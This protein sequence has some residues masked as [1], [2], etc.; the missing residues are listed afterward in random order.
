VEVAVP[1]ASISLRDVGRTFG[2]TRAL[3]D[4]DLDLNPGVIGLLGP[5]GAGK[6]TTLSILATVLAPD[7]GSLRI[8]GFD[9]Y[10]QK[11]GIRRS[12]GFVPQ[13]IALYPSLTAAE[14]L[15]L[16]LRMHGLNRGAARDACA[17]TLQVVGLADRA[18]DPV[19]T[20]SGGMQRRLNLA[21]GI[22]H[23]P[24]ILLL[25]EPTTGVDPQSRN[26]ILRTI[27]RLADAGA[28][29]LYSTHYMEEVER[30]CDRVLLIDRGRVIA[31]GSVAE[32][33]A[34]ADKRPRI[35]FTFAARTTNAWYEGI[36]AIEL[37]SPV[38]AAGRLTL[39][40]ASVDAVPEL[41]KRA[42]ELDGGL[43]DFT[44]RSANL[45]DAFMALTGRS[46][47]HGGPS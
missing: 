11:K 2:A 40:L 28:A 3:A 30:L 26:R 22:S 18:G 23:Q 41:L 34:M 16:F 14:N 20:L 8:L 27:R 39:A 29:V 17:Q 6:T 31:S 25:D 21:C 19:A 47:R 24:Q 7:S 38:S 45:S 12:L 1:T 42:R 15:Q 5:N 4:V 9:A 13:S 36:D 33:I 44:I 35:E 37:P 43:R 10:T 46:L 32:V